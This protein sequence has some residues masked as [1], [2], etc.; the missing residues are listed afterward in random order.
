MDQLWEVDILPTLMDYIRIPN[1]S[2]AFDPE[3]ETN[4]HMMRAVQLAYQWCKDH[5][6]DDM[7]AEIFSSP[8]RTPLLILE[9]PGQSEGT[10]LLYGHLDKQ[11]PLEGSW[12]DGLGPQ[13]PVREGDKLYGRGGA[14]DGYAMFASLGALLLLREQGIPHPRCFILIECAEESGGPDLSYYVTQL[15]GRIGTPELVVCLD[16]SCGNYEQLWLT[17]SLRGI[18]GGVLTISVLTEEV[19]SGDGSGIVPSSFRIARTL[20]ERIED[21]H[22]GRIRDEFQVEIP[23]ECL[24]EAQ[25]VAKIP[26]FDPFSRF[27]WAPGTTPVT[28]DTLTGVINRTWRPA[29]EITG[30]GGLPDL[31]NAGN[32]LRPNTALTL[33]MR[34]PPTLDAQTAGKTLKGMLE[35]E[36]PYGA[37][38]HYQE[39][40]S[41]TGWQA[42]RFS[43]QLDSTLQDASQHFFGKPAIYYGE[44]FSIPFMSDLVSSFPDAQ[45][46]VTGVLGPHANA[47]G[48]NEFLHIEMAKKITLCIAEILANQAR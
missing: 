27:P 48:P 6:P 13:N 5:G 25:T 44:G 30:A 18:I 31:G 4:G 2:P 20:L 34:I 3:W 11:P 7:T 10:V 19:H 38:V 42:P 1:Q 29:L 45:F 21:H 24:E 43:S 46:I 33:S 37:Q 36:P 16:S 40:W 35:S 39:A 15:Q 14:D 22:T 17:T 9:I 47:H 26:G 28:T 23:K 32:V 8:H 41:V 12:R